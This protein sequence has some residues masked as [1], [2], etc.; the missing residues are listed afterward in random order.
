M[1]HTITNNPNDQI[2]SE[3]F[4][5]ESAIGT[6]PTY[7][8]EIIGDRIIWTSTDDYYAGNGDLYAAGTVLRDTDLIVSEETSVLAEI[9]AISTDLEMGFT[10]AWYTTM[11]REPFE[12]VLNDD[13]TEYVTGPRWRLL[14]DK[15]GQD[16]PGV[17]IPTD[18]SD[19]LP[20]TKDQEKYEV[21]AETQT[22][23]NL[24]DWES[25][26]SPLEISA[27]WQNNSGDVSVNGVNMTDDFNVAFYIKGDVKPATVYSAEVLLDYEEVALHS[28]DTT[29]I[30]TDASDFLV[31]IGNNEFTGVQAKTCSCCLMALR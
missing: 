15:Y 21:G 1:H 28:Q 11:N 20:V 10:N 22:V 6:L 16:L 2:R 24:L 25:P 5:N 23:I 17:V 26:I 4:E 3:D 12:P 8:E 18:P 27:G 13:G 29:I 19:P 31:G 30:G 7:V 14:P 9:G